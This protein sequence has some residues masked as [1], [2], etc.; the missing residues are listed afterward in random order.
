MLDL[1]LKVVGRWREVLNMVWADFER[2]LREWLD[3]VTVPANYFRRSPESLFVPVAATATIDFA[4]DAIDMILNGL[5]SIPFIVAGS[6]IAEEFKV[7]GELRKRVMTL[8]QAALLPVKIIIEQ[9]LKIV[10]DP[11]PQDWQTYRFADRMAKI[12]DVIKKPTAKR[13]WKIL[14]GSVWTRVVRLV[15]IVFA[16]GK[17]V[18][19]VVLLWNYVRRVSDK[20]T[21]PILF[22]GALSQSNPRAIQ[23]TT[24]NRRVG[25]VPP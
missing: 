11:L 20:S 15:L 14:F 25:G 21:W 23:R 8:D 13:F 10:Q 5:S 4:F 16:I 18:G 7:P 3:I 12:E 24:V 1:I 22:A 6:I 17:M 2:R 9:G 19:L